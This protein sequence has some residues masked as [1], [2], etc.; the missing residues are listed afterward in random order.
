MLST[1][2]KGCRGEAGR[3]NFGRFYFTLTVTG[4]WTG[5]TVHWVVQSNADR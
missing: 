5:C 4:I 1:L 3:N 2:S